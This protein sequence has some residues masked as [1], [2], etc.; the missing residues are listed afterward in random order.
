MRALIFMCARSDVSVVDAAFSRSTIQALMLLALCK[1]HSR[2][3][4]SALQ[5]SDERWRDNFRLCGD[6]PKSITGRR[7]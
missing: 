3:G 5:Q 1:V 7:I 2:E 4:K 6:M